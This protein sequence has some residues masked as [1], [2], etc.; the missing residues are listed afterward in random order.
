MRILL[1][2]LLQS[3]SPNQKYPL[4]SYLYLKLHRSKNIK[5]NKITVIWTN[6]LSGASLSKL[7]AGTLLFGGFNSS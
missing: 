3:V 2:E 6:F 4:V 7:V 1:V 5:N